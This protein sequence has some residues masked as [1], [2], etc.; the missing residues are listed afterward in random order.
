VSTEPERLLTIEQAAERTGYPPATIN[1]WR[2]RGLPYI[3]AGAG[4]A[5]PRL[6]DIR[7]RASALW[8]WVQQLEIKRMA[9][10]AKAPRRTP[11]LAA[12]AVAGLGAWRER[13]GE[14]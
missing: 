9:S 10:P 7:I 8:E 11:K 5:R 13:K 12:G 4:R 3:A 14:A 2:A 1:E 6:K